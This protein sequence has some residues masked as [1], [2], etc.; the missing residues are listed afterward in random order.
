MA[1]EEFEF[2]DGRFRECINPTARVYKLFEGCAWAEGPAWSPGWRSLVWSDI[3]NDRQLRW[4]ESNG[5][6]GVFRTPAGNT[7]GN[8]VDRQGRLLSCEHSGRRVSRTEFDGTVVTIVD[9]YNGKRL[10]SP[11]DVVVKSDDSIWF[12]DP[13]YG[14]ESDYEGNRSEME[15]DGCYVFRVDPA[16]GDIR[17]AAADFIRPNGIAFSPDE[18]LL[19]VSD[20]GAS[21]GPDGPRHIRRFTVNADNSLSDSTDFATCSAGFFDGFR[22]D[23][24]GR[25][26]ASTGEG[27][28]VF[29]ADGTLIGKVLVPEVVANVEFGGAKRNHLFI[30][31]TTSLYT[32]KVKTN[33]AQRI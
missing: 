6:V 2:V 26:W 33:G 16:D 11:N 25:V 19:Y 13:A 20:T 23:V 24:D 17:V 3:P 5:T 8:T 14:I 12:T 4:D 9:S 27:V 1:A 10:N 18:S 30:C 31:G 21:H 29:D 15:Q 28:H 22:V 7:N 32:V